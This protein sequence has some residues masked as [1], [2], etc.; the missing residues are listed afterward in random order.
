MNK[1][2]VFFRES[3][4]AVFLIPLG[5]TL[6][7]FSMLLFVVR[8][9]NKNYI[10]I[11]ATVSKV[12]LYSEESFDVDG[13]VE[14]AQYTIYVKYV[15]DE[16]EYENELGIMFE[17]KVGDKIKIVYNPEDPNQ[18]SSPS[19]LILNITLL[20]GGIAALIGGICS[21][22]NSI[23]RQKKLKSQEEAW[24]NGK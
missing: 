8:D 4:L 11:E 5:I 10:E 3:K 1:L 16:K 21:A 18:I 6:I 20:I 14:P 17:H 22:I 19:S 13:N 24:S 2:A 7:V 9:N 23:N 12:E 15:V